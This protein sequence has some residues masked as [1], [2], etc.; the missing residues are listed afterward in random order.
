MD[1]TRAKAPAEHAAARSICGER[2][3]KTTLTPDT[4]PYDV[5]MEEGIAVGGPTC[6]VGTGGGG[7]PPA[8]ATAAPDV[9]AGASVKLGKV[10]SRPPRRQGLPSRGAELNSSPP[11]PAYGA[12]RGSVEVRLPPQPGGEGVGGDG[13]GGW[14]RGGGEGG[15]S[16]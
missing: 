1:C 12:G 6:Q 8:R 15:G 7:R 5:P 2:T 9:R 16:A 10:E 3:E 14:S 11:P 13:E 4:W